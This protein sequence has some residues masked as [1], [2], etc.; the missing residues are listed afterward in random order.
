MTPTLW[1]LIQSAVQVAHDPSVGIVAAN[2]LIVAIG[3]SIVHTLNRRTG[4]KRDAKHEAQLAAL[5]EQQ[6]I[7]KLTTE[8]LA[9][10]ATARD[11]DVRALITALAL[12]VRELTVLV[13]NGLA[14]NVENIMERMDRLEQREIERAERR[15]EA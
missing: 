2:G 8:K 11:T 12:E 3:G 14:A 1:L 9:E 4:H 10:I 7:V 5:E 13:R 15:R 6:R